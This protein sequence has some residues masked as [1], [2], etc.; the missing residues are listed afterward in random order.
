MQKVVDKRMEEEKKIE[1]E[2]QKEKEYKLKLLQ[3][4]KDVGKQLIT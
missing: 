1:E 2:K 4:K 3:K